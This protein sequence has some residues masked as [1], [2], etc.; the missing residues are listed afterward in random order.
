MKIVAIIL[1]VIIVVLIGVIIFVPSVKSPTTSQNA[2]STAPLVSADGRLTVTMPNANVLITSPVAIEGTVTGGGWFFEASFPIKVLDGDGKVLGQGTAQA[3]SDW[4][5]TGTVP[6]AASIPFTAPRFAIG[7]ILLQNDNP[8]GLP[9][10][11]KSLSIPVR[12]R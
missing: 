2:S 5:T 8:S 1:A 4:M 6:F 10:N 9:A 11:Q 3:L 7:T 12:F